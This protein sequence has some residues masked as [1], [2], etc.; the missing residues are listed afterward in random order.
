MMKFDDINSEYTAKFYETYN[1]VLLIFH[2][3]RLKMYRLKLV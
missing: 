3:T 1:A 2:S